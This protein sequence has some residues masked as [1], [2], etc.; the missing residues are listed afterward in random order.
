MSDE[1]PQEA[2]STAPLSDNTVL[3]MSVF[4]ERKDIP[5]RGGSQVRFKDTKP[6]TFQGMTLEGVPVTHFPFS[7]TDDEIVRGIL[8]HVIAV[9][10]GTRMQGKEDSP[11]YQEEYAA[12]SR[13]LHERYIP[14][15]S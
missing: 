10:A 7:G 2:E 9:L 4:G 15:Q 13:R 1:Q 3:T 8:S 12:I 14:K 6:Y 11:T 5:E